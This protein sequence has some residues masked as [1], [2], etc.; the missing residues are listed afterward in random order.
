MADTTTTIDSATLPKVNLSFFFWMTLVMAFVVF[1]GFGTSYFQ[2]MAVGTLRPVAPIVHIHGLFYFAWMILLVVQSWLV[3]NKSI[4]L[5][6]SMGLAG[7]SI[8]TGIVFLAST[9]TFLSTGRDLAVNPSAFVYEL[10]YL[11]L[12]AII[13]FAILFIYA[14]SNIRDS[15]AHK[16]FILL[17]TV[18]FLAGGLNR[19]FIF[20]FEFEFTPFW[21]LYVSV[22]LIILAFLVYDWRTLGKLHRATLIG[23]AINIVPQ[24]LHGAIANSSAFHSLTHWLVGF[25]VYS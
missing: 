23:A 15:E 21:I 14:I 20:M 3:N 25:T 1:A 12:L 24:L 17:A 7:I 11:S 5:H 19:I 9:V 18:A 8:A 22:D 13:A 10:M 4:A 6:R 2:P 16:R